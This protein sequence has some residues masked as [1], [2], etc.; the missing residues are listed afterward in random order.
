[1]K[2][3]YKV[4]A[5]GPKEVDLTSW[6]GKLPKP[7][8]IDTSAEYASIDWPTLMQ[9]VRAVLT[10][11]NPAYKTLVLELTEDA[12]ELCK[13][14]VCVKH[15]VNDISEISD[16]RGPVYIQKEYGRLLN[17][18]NEVVARGIHVVITTR[19]KMRK[20]C[21]PDGETGESLNRWELDLPKYVAQTA[22]E[23]CDALLFFNLEL[24][25]T[26][27]EPHR[28]T[29]NAVKHTVHTQYHREWD[30][31]NRMNLP[32]KLSIDDSTLVNL[33]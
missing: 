1:M 2:T 33:F 9:M 17:L 5:Y 18:L 23:W 15:G 11:P 29:A 6:T 13:T 19:A 21:L 8:C 10:T 31:K 25:V 28:M 27:K 32:E 3:A 12:E 26:P 24:D 16:H 4:I 7:L 14:H 30:A 20:M 22:M